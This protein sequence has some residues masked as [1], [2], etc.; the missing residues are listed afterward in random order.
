MPSPRRLPIR[1]VESRAGA[2]AMLARKKQDN[3]YGFR[4]D[5]MC[6][7]E[8]ECVVNGEGDVKKIGLEPTMEEFAAHPA[9]QDYG[10][11]FLQRQRSKVVE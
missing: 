2:R 6:F 4:V 9:C 11:E 8:V 5:Y 10:P 3:E 7:G 1:S